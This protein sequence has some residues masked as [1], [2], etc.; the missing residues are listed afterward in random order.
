MMSGI[1]VFGCWSATVSPINTTRR[2]RE[3]R[4][5][6]YLES[7]YGTTGNYQTNH[8]NRTF[9]CHRDVWNTPRLAFPLYKRAMW[10]SSTWIIRLI[11]IRLLS[12]LHQ[13][14]LR[15]IPG[16]EKLR[17]I[18]C[19][20]N[21]SPMYSSGEIFSEPALNAA[22]RR[23]LTKPSTTREPRFHDKHLLKP[24]SAS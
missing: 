22:G 7:D 19:A 16:F 12:R 21:I 18:T 4:I 24:F 1:K 3:S 13:H 9:C 15:S 11:S 14:S 6:E 2:Y 5:S 20:L 17:K 23:S 10:M 8:A